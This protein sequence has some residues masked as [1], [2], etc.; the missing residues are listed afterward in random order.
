MSKYK[1][2][3]LICAGFLALVNISCPSPSTLVS[4]P[5]VGGMTQVAAALMLT[6][7]Q[8]QV[9]DVSEAW[10]DAVDAGLVAGQT[11]AAGAKVDPNTAVDLVIS[12]GPAPS[13][14]WT[15][16][17]AANAIW[18][19]DIEPTADGGYI[20]SGGNTWYN[21]YALKLTAA[22]GYVWD[23][24]YSRLTTNSNQSEL[25]RSKAF[26]VKQTADGGYVLL[27][28][29][30]IEDDGLPEQSFILLKVTS[31]GVESWAKSY[32]PANPWS[33]GHYAG[34]NDPAALDLLADGS[35]VAFGSS[36]VGMYG[37]SSILKTDSAGNGTFHHVVD[38]HDNDIRD[39]EEIVEAG[40]KT[41]DG[42]FILVAHG[43]NP[44]PDY[45]AYL[46]KLNA[47]GVW[48][49]TKAYQDT[50]NGY[51]AEA[52]A[53]TQTADGGFLLCGELYNDIV[54]KALGHGTWIAKTDS[55]GNLLWFERY[56]EGS[57]VHLPRAIE[58]L[59]DGGILV[60]GYDEVGSMQVAKFTANGIFMWRLRMTDFGPKTVNDFVVN[61]DGTCVLVGSGSTGGPTVVVQVEHVYVPDLK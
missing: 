4:V 6:G 19:R 28:R 2:I 52:Y 31:S 22:G 30:H 18:G 33:A 57:R 8:L 11:P 21:M 60:G 47:A 54:N 38:T 55:S 41:A 37:L 56:A 26:G 43:S 32:A 16:T 17:P 13:I 58:E 5:D 39:F 1:F 50:V 9:G 44:G 7:A 15:Y 46:I 59:P 53:V 25:W 10:S 45:S 35:L 61:D 24:T 49:W 27:G 29:G 14:G 48:Q 40:Q 51:G 36:Y 20:V 42:G 23:A 34:P 12:L 3:C